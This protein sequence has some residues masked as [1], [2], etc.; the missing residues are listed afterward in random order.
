MNQI[1]SFKYVLDFGFVESGGSRKMR[2]NK[3]TGSGGKSRPC[4]RDRP[5]KRNS[6]KRESDRPDY[7]TYR[8]SAAERRNCI[9]V[10]AVL[11]M[12]VSYLFFDTAAVFFL[13]APGYFFFQKEYRDTLKRKRTGEMKREFLDGM[14]MTA[15]S[16]QAGYSIE[17][18]FGEAL[19]ELRKIY[20]AESFIMQEFRFLAAQIDMNRNIEELL[21]DMGRRSGVEDIRSFAEI[22]ETA[23][24]TGG[25]LL[26]VIQNTVS[27]MRQRQETYE[28]IETC[29]AGK[30]MEQNVMNVV[31]VLILGYVRL[32]SPEFLRSMYGNITGI[33]VMSLCLIV[34]LAAV[35]W[36]KSMI[37]IEV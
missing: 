26:G 22:V 15:S 21:L 11:D 16:L 31:P 9:A 4:I 3:F 8:L 1:W 5:G 24:R 25:N 28:E 13:L 23:K 20:G 27:C 17:N 19:K 30:I 29:L 12:V 2:R 6:A 14:Q 10:Y 34:Y 36:G 33:A 18:A 37:Q 7:T 35:L 32:T